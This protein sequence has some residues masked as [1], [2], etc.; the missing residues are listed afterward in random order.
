MCPVVKY[1]KKP[2]SRA[3]NQIAGM[4]K[5]APANEVFATN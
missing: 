4:P 3:A 2:P 1:R 5:I